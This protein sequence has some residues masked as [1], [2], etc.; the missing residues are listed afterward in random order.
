MNANLIAKLAKF[1]DSHDN[2]MFCREESGKL[3][4]ASLVVK[5]GKAEMLRE[6]IEPTLQ[7][8]RDWLG[9]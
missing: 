4:V 3:I 8:V 1:I 9:Y 7:A 6:T 2:C 5:D